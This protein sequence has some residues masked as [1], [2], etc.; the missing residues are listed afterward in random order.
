MRHIAAL[1][2]AAGIALVGCD[3][4]SDTNRSWRPVGEAASFLQYIDTGSV[5]NDGS[6]V[7]FWLRREY[8]EAQASGSRRYDEELS[9][10]RIDCRARTVRVLQSEQRMDGATVA[11]GG[12]ARE[13]DPINPDSV[14]QD[15]LEFVCRP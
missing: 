13:E 6:R 3:D 9:R 14:M 1:A 8:S 12:D 2:C 11:R 10:Q 15:V 7:T 5:Q 4:R